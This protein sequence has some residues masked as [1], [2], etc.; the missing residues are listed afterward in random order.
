MAVQ[1]K[2]TTKTAKRL[3]L[4]P[5][6]AR[7]YFGEENAQPLVDFLNRG[8]KTAALIAELID[9]AARLRDSTQPL[10]RQVENRM[11]ATLHVPGPLKKEFR[12]M[13]GFDVPK[14][15]QEKA[16]AKALFDINRILRGICLTPNLVVTVRGRWIASWVGHGV[17]GSEAEALFKFLQLASDDL[18]K[19]IK[20]CENS[21]CKM[22]L[23]A[24]P[25]QKR[26]H[27]KACQEKVF[28]SDEGR[29]AA[30]REW[31]KKHYHAF[32]SGRR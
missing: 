13:Q 29:K 16:R 8:G 31:A 4:E 5:E 10:P 19:R 23:F 6:R 12:K 1:N 15:G 2:R 14:P 7:K 18:L 17:R 27:S 28:E 25:P 30:R 20:R 3:H 32:I 21:D 22:W 9:A 11:L 26:F 24:A